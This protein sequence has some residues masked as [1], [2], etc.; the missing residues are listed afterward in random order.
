[1]IQV[2]PTKRKKER[3]GTWRKVV[4]EL[5][6]FHSVSAFNR[7]LLSLWSGWVAKT[8]NDHKRQDDYGSY[9]I[10]TPL[11]YNGLPSVAQ[12][13]SMRHLH[14]RYM[15]FHSIHGHCSALAVCIVAMDTFPLH[16]ERRWSKQSQEPAAYIVETFWGKHKWFTLLH[17]SL[18]QLCMVCLAGHW[19]VMVGIW[20]GRLWLHFYEMVDVSPA[21]NNLILW[22][23]RQCLLRHQCQVCPTRFL[24]S[25]FA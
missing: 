1:M 15:R 17:S 25:L 13:T 22:H 6:H 24:Y 23:Y 16:P 9:A 7:R 20:R 2:R 21:V 11:A 18:S 12:R 19:M 8:L 14:R 3:N 10:F 5:E 4:L